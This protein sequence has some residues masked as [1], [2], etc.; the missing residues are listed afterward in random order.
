MTKVF[1]VEFDLGASVESIVSEEVQTITGESQRIL[2]NAIQHQQALKKAK[3]QKEAAKKSVDDA[4]IRVMSEAYDQL[5]EAGET[6]IPVNTLVDNAKPTIPNSS[7]FTLRMKNILKE[8]G[9]PYALKRKQRNKI[10]HYIFEP[11]NEQPE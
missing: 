8:K 2:D 1:I 5:L 4:I 10:P 7:A 9:N 3:E 6:G 11:F